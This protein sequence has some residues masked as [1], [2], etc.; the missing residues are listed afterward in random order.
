[1]LLAAD[2][3]VTSPLLVA[4]ALEKIFVVDEKIAILYSGLVG[5]ART[6]VDYAREVAENH[7]VMYDEPISVE[8]LAR[9]ISRIKQIYTQYGGIRPFGVSFLIAGYSNAPHLF[10]TQPSGTLLEYKADAI[11]NRKYDVMGLLEKKWKEGIPFKAA[12][13]L[14]IDALKVPLEEGETLTPDRV[15]IAYVEKDTQFTFLPRDEVEKYIG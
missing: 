3:K 11:G 5:D 12:I 14:A 7:R 8:K 15:A 9:E 6:L 1:M 2:R 10:E 4:P 13:E